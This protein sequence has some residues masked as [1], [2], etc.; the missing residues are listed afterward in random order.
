MPNQPPRENISH[1]V[2][3]VIGTQLGI[4]TVYQGLIALTFLGNENFGFLIMDMLA[5][6]THWIF[7]L[8]MMIVSFTNSKKG[9][10]IGYLLALLLTGV[11]GFGSCI[12]IGQ[13]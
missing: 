7:L 5:L 10:G 9:K 13:I 1:D 6:I 3:K 4:F 12:F 2:W 8:V 11:I